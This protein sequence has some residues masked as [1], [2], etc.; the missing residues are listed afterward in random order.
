[1]VIFSQIDIL[2][3][4]RVLIL[5]KDL[6]QTK[7]VFTKYIYCNNISVFDSGK[8]DIDVYIPNRCH[9]NEG[10]PK[11]FPAALD[12]RFRKLILI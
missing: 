6:C 3:M 1:M 4:Q 8:I 9:S 10:P 11:P 7:E 5:D 2:L 12:K